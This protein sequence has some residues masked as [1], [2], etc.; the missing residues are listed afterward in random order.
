MRSGPIDPPM[1]FQSQRTKWNARVL[2]RLGGCDEGRTRHGG[3]VEEAKADPPL[4][5]PLP[6][7]AFRLLGKSRENPERKRS[8]RSFGGS[9]AFPESR[10]D[11]GRVPFLGGR[12]ATGP[13][14]TAS[15]KAKR[16]R[17]GEGVERGPPSPPQH[18]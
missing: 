12:N 8:R 4:G 14:R 10:Q 7:E 6:A 5:H 16:L 1:D 17:G 18:N 11:A 13:C 3:E 15:K 9:E 2:A